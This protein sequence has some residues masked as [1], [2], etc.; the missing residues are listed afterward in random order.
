MKPI[1]L[2]LSLCMPFWARPQA[3]NK[4]S[5][6]QVIKQIRQ[7]PVDTVQVR[8]LRELGYDIGSVDSALARE[9]I[10]ESLEKSLQLKD[11]RAITSAYRMLGLWYSG[12]GNRDKAMENYR[13]SQSVAQKYDLPYLEAGA[14]F[15]IGNI[16]YYQGQYDSSIFYFQKTQ[17][18]FEHPDIIEKDGQITQRVL[19]KK[20][21]DLYSNI[22]SI[23]NTLGNYKKSDEYID[24]AL[25]IAESYKA[26]AVIAQYI[27]QKADNLSQSGAAEAAL[28]LRLQHLADM[29]NSKIE[30]PFI[31]TYY[32]S[33]ARDYEKLEKLDSAKIYGQKAFAFAKELEVPDALASAS[34][35]MGRLSIGEKNFTAAKD[36]L[37]LSNTYYE[38]SEDPEEQR[39]YYDVMQQ[40]NMGLGNYRE[41]YAYLEKFHAVNDT[42]LNGERTRQFSEREAR[43]QSE[44]KDAQIK[45]S[46]AEL[47]EK[48]TLNFLLGGS[49]AAL[50]IIGLL[51]YRNYRH[52]QAI[53][54]QRI[55]EL[56]TEKQL[57]ATESVLKGEEQERTR[58]AKDLHDGLG[59]M[60]S[61]IKYSMNAIKGNLILTP[62]NASAFER[63][64][65]MLD[66]S[67]HEMRR[68]AHNLMP[69]ALVKFGLDAALKDVCEDIDRSG[70][71]QVTYQS[72]G[73]EG[74]APEQ[75]VS[76]TIYRIV[77]E[78]LNN[79]MKHAAAKHAVVQLSRSSHGI[80]IT[81]EDDG[82][83]FDP[84]QLQHNAG[85]GW[86][87]IRHRVELV[88]GKLDV[89]SAPGKG[90]SVYIEIP[91]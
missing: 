72:V 56:E 48:S 57:A 64:M 24:K 18:L 81:V 91:A 30:R 61:G 34:L 11:G 1:L 90:T 40:L 71:L 65:E 37:K 75:S 2:L 27:Q 28:R 44:A 86:S 46:K 6:R 49:L 68:V 45:L 10:V 19:D 15:N 42:I 26:K 69:E 82:K 70:V 5:I 25:A 43:Y 88:K 20:K 58:L 33:I 12:I 41:A 79:T 4:D 22:S 67:I 87:N 77:Q 76:I 52:K 21:S 53:Q 63:S 83:G 84:G 8:L 3:Y 9:I 47:K 23:F 16:K 31:Q 85:I 36:Y 13:L 60:L 50:L 51:A 29:E 66:S 35:L 39:E 80:S 17:T 32:Q 73:L 55:V 14:Y 7:R 59:G 38:A 78:L 74:K 89:Q 54:R 62:E